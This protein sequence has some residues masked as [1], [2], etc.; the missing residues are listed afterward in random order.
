MRELIRKSTIA[1]SAVFLGIWWAYAGIVGLK[2]FTHTGLAKR[3]PIHFC[4]DNR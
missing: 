2:M 1:A 4:E 3:A